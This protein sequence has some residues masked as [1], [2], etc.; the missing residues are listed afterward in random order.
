MRRSSLVIGLFG[1]TGKM[2]SRHV[3]ERE[4]VEI[5]EWESPWLSPE[6]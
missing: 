2:G 3:L 4:I 6:T 1:M 5:V